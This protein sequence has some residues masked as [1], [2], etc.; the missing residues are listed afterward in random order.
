VDSII[1]QLFSET[2]RRLR[3]VTFD[4]DGTTIDSRDKVIAI[5]AGLAPRF[6]LRE[7]LPYDGTSILNALKKLG[8]SRFAQWRYLRECRKRELRCAPQIFPGT[9]E[10]VLR[11]KTLGKI[12]GIVT[13]RPADR[14][15][16]ALFRQSGLDL[17]AFDIMVTYDANP[18]RVEW[19]KRWGLLGN[20][21]K[22]HV[23]VAYPKPDKRAF[24]PVCELT[25]HI[26]CSPGEVAHFGDSIPDVAAARENYFVPIGV[27]T[28]AV[29]HKAVFY[30][31]GAQFVIPCITDARDYL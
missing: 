20:V 27:L 30:E 5:H 22:C 31:H 2:L 15:T 24:D 13:N 19:K 6:G 11:L 18:S 14:H 4:A 25:G 12:V 28:G 3:I 9:N 16:F 17:D 10:L 26:G 8:L 23:S 1:R 21:P 29:R 7:P